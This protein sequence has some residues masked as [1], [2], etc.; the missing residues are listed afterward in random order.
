MAN[1]EAP[2]AVVDR[3]WRGCVACQMVRDHP[4]TPIDQTWPVVKE[5]PPRDEAEASLKT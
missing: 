3:G 1:L 5:G 4:P 2:A